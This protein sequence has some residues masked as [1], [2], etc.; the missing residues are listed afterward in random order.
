MKQNLRVVKSNKVIE[1]GYRMTLN[2]QRLILACIAQIK[3]EQV[4]SVND[5]FRDWVIG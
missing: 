1:A 4:V 5:K 2:E 3:K